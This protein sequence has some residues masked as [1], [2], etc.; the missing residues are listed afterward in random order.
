MCVCVYIMTI[1]LPSLSFI[2][3]KAYL[4]LVFPKSKNKKWS[5]SIYKVKRSICLAKRGPI[6]MAFSK[7]KSRIIAK[8]KEC[9]IHL[10]NIEAIEQTLERFEFIE[11]SNR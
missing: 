7:I 10:A 11:L 1:V 8:V 5:Y 6:P 4:L 2:I 9:E 3:Q